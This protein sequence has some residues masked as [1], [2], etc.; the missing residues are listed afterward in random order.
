MGSREAPL[1]RMMCEISSKYFLLVLLVGLQL[2]IK[3]GEAGPNGTVSQVGGSAGQAKGG[4][5]P[6]TV[7]E[8]SVKRYIK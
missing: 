4:C 8:K 6:A 5:A 3:C 7:H 1:L 2:S